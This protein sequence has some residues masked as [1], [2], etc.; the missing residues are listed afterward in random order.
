MYLN[1]FECMCVYLLPRI[2]QYTMIPLCSGLNVNGLHKPVRLN[3]WSPVDGIA[4]EELGGITLLEVCYQ[5]QPLK[6]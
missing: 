2:L 5:A 1:F 6:L 4:W 3:T